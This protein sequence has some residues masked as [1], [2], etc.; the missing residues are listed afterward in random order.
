MNMLKFP[1][2]GRRGEGKVSSFSLH[3]PKT[4]TKQPVIARIFLQDNVALKL[5]S[6]G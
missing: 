5:E 6:K 3:I 1:V 2:G 4:F